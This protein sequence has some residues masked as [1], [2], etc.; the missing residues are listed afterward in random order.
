MYKSIYLVHACDIDGSH[1]GIAGIYTNK[2][3]AIE[4]IVNHYCE[5]TEIPV[6]EIERARFDL[7][8]YYHTQDI[9]GADNYDIEVKPLDEWDW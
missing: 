4:H 8:E 6:S 9:V 2:E 7:N 1:K 3:L 5:D